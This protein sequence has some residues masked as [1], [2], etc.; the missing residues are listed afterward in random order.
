MTLVTKRRCLWERHVTQ[1]LNLNSGFC[2]VG[3]VTVVENAL[4]WPSVSLLP[5]YITKLARHRPPA[6]LQEIVPSIDTPTPPVHNGHAQSRILRR[7]S[8]QEPTDIH[9]MVP[10]VHFLI[11]RCLL[12]ISCNQGS[13]Q[14][15]G[16]RLSLR[17]VSDTENPRGGGGLDAARRAL[18]H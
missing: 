16:G 13:L 5:R 14:R 10:F 1:T 4:V 9:D 2:S 6:S 12:V 17:E 8:R 3:N 15:A 7:Q 11:S 18:S